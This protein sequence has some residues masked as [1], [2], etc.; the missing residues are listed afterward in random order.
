MSQSSAGYSD[1]LPHVIH[2]IISPYPQQGTELT[3]TRRFFYFLGDLTPSISTPSDKKQTEFRKQST[4][5][6][7]LTVIPF[8]SAY[9][10]VILSI[11]KRCK[12]IKCPSKTPFHFTIF[13]IKWALV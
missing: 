4:N 11:S 13:M 10:I 6:Q 8:G 3:K 9:I 1:N 2:R 12:I 7:R 5:P